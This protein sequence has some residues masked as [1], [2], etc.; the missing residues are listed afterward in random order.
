MVCQSTRQ[1]L[2][3]LPRTAVSTDQQLTQSSAAFAL[4][5]GAEASSS[6][7]SRIPVDFS[8]VTTFW[9]MLEAVATFALALGSEASSSSSSWIPVHNLATL[10]SMLA[11]VKTAGFS[12][13]SQW[14][15]LQI[16]FAFTILASSAKNTA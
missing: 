8:G 12:L 11:D 5:M 16:W 3:R 6:T 4:A 15:P 13:I 2:H 7:S 10:W 1:M 9:S 14:G